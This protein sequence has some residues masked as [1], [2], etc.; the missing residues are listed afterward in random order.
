MG[1]KREGVGSG[2]PVHVR[3]L[4]V[5][6]TLRWSWEVLTDRPELVG[7]ALVVSLL[8]AVPLAGVSRPSPAAPPEFE[9]WVWPV[10]LVYAVAVT[11][12]WAVTYATADDAVRR[13]SPPLGDRFLGVSSRIPALLATA[14]LMWTVSLVGALFLVLPGIYLFHRLLLAYPAVVIDG[15]GPVGSLRASW[16]AAGGNVLKVLAVSLGYFLLVAASNSVAGA[17][18]QFT[19]ASGVV[20]A[21]PAAVLIPLFGLA[22]GHLYLET[23]RNT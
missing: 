22:F 14:V 19:L 15:K 20:S 21:V 13:R 1:T 23:S 18:G 2:G 6:D 16:S 9:G 17:F 8:S 12:V 5:A 3:T 4:D 7:L 11:G 10:F